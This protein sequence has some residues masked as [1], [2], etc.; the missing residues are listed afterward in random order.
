MIKDNLIKASKHPV[1]RSKMLL[2][3]LINMEKE[4]KFN[5][6][7]VK[8]LAKHI[9]TNTP[10]NSK[11]RYINLQIRNRLI[12]RPSKHQPYFKL[13]ITKNVTHNINDKPS[14]SFVTSKLYKLTKNT[15]FIKIKL[16][17]KL[18]DEKIRK[19]L[20][21]AHQKAMEGIKSFNQE[22]KGLINESKGLL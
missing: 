13:S 8:E 21:E 3:I 5:C 14:T 22:M 7:T 16:E 11:I 10:L 1:V 20:E 12:I 19:E 4:G 18:M 2:L 9:P 17:R 15:Y 6:L